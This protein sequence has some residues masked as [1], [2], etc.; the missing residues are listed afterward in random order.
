M[1]KRVGYSI[2]SLILCCRMANFLRQDSKLLPAIKTGAQLLGMNTDWLQK[3]AALPKASTI[4]KAR[5]IL[6]AGYSLMMQSYWGRLLSGLSSCFMF[7]S[8][9]SSPRSG[10]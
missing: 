10:R 4:S 8:C 3:S 1:D 9:D 5:F 7:M 6:D 2:E